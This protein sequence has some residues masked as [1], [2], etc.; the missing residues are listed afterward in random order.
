MSHTTTDTGAT[1]A[2]S[3]RTTHRGLRHEEAD[4]ISSCIGTE[5]AQRSGSVSLMSVLCVLLC[6]CPPAMAQDTVSAS[7]TARLLQPQT[8]RLS[9]RSDAWVT[10][11]FL[12]CQPYTQAGWSMCETR[13]WDA[14]VHL[15]LD[16]TL[17]AQA[18]AGVG[19]NVQLAPNAD[20]RVGL[21]VAALVPSEA[22]HMQLI[23][24]PTLGVAADVLYRDIQRNL[25]GNVQAVLT[26]EGR[27][28]T[29][30][31]AHY[32]FL[33]SQ[34]A[35]IAGG[36]GA[37][38]TH[39]HSDALS[40]AWSA[41]IGPHVQ[42]GSLSVFAG[43]G[44][45]RALGA[46]EGAVGA[47]FA[48]EVREYIPFRSRASTSSTPQVT[49]DGNTL[50]VPQPITFEADSATLTAGS[51]AALDA[52]AAYMLEHRVAVQIA[53]HTDARGSD[54]YNNRLSLERAEA[55]KRAAEDEVPVIPCGGG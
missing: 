4:V 39:T 53:G 55:V 41:Y 31:D 40:D 10:F 24:G 19:Y 36:I 38:G 48:L 3:G 9:A 45:A 27:V 54:G 16:Y 52:M 8:G 50:N 17:G 46:R 14:Q 28:H 1:R 37:A 25:V 23:A 22:Q 43:A 5:H 13:T 49:R 7:E 51:E 12:T 30:A 18:G 21:G 26:R 44:Y 34:N 11:G 42:F 35:P 32:D 20:L 2:A 29:S 15:S 33:R 6:L 47:L